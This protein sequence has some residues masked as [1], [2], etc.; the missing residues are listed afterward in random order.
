V[1]WDRNPD[2]YLGFDPVERDLDTKKDWAFHTEVVQASDCTKDFGMP[3]TSTPFRAR[4]FFGTTVLL[5]FSF[6]GCGIV[7]G[8]DEFEVVS[9]GASGTGASSSSSGGEQ[10]VTIGGSV[11]GLEGAGLV[12]QNNGTDNIQI[13]MNGAFTFPAKLQLGSGYDVTIASMPTSPSQSCSVANGMGTANGP[14]TNVEIVCSTSTYAVGGTVVGLSGTGLV[15]TNGGGDDLPVSMS[16]AFQFPTKVASGAAFDV[17]VK[18]Q[19]SSG[20]PC[21][22]SG[23]TG[24]VGNA[25][26]S[27][28]IVN[29]A[30]GTYTVGGTISGLVGAVILQQNGAANLNLTSDG[31]FAF[32]QTLAPGAMYNVTVATQPSYPPRSQSCTIMNGGGTMG[33]ANVTNVMVSCAT[34]AYTVGGNV[35]GTSGPVVLNNNGGDQITVNAAGAFTFPTSVQSGNTYSVGVVT[36]PA[37]QTCLVNAGSGTVAN[38]NISDVTVTCSTAMGNPGILC[39]GNY[40]TLGTEECCYSNN[41]YTCVAKCTGG[42]T[43]PVRCDSAA[44]CM[45]GLICCGVITSGVVN[46]LYCTGASQCTAPKILFCDPAAANPCPNGGTCMA[47]DVPPGYYRC[48]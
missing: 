30:P 44:D 38:G 5:V 48:N 43:S 42:G 27:S 13:G 14:I 35:V 33:N 10:F 12:L 40:C 2:G 46:S 24:V 47:T 28:V 45:P 3:Q 1:A 6:M 20:G 21:V 36:P 4:L 41:S 7:S 15:L 16:G 23:G 19:P 31:T 9:T 18:T 11:S 37:G 25:D 34:Q 39:D 29:C 22:V 17:A 32:A 26:V 8:L